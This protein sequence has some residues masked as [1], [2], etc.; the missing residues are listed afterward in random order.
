[1]TTYL[2]LCRFACETGSGILLGSA[3]S[4]RR[5]R[6]EHARRTGSQWR[7]LFV[8]MAHLPL[9]EKASSV[10]IG[11]GCSRVLYRRFV[12]YRHPSSFMAMQPVDKTRHKSQ[13]GVDRFSGLEEESEGKLTVGSIAPHSVSIT[14]T[15]ELKSTTSRVRRNSGRKKGHVI[16]LRVVSRH[17]P[18]RCV[19]CSRVGCRRD[20]C[21]GFG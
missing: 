16:G 3:H 17:G 6:R 21:V 8:V 2:P 20:S 1:M 13:P 12:I 7:E 9:Q 5:L 10:N 14:Y 19:M 4:H 18:V 11:L 15:I